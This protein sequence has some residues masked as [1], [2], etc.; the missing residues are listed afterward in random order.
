M[1]LLKESDI[2]VKESSFAKKDDGYPTVMGSY[3]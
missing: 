1:F 2:H 3:L